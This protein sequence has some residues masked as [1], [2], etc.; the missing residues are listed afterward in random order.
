M[1]RNIRVVLGVAG[2]QEISTSVASSHTELVVELAKE[3]IKLQFASVD[4]TLE[5]DE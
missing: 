5:V 1:L 3:L 2:S 4:T